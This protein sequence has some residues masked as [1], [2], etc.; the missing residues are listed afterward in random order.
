MASPRS[1]LYSTVKN[2]VEHVIASVN[3]D[4]VESCGNGDIKVKMDDL[5]DVISLI[6]NTSQ[7]ATIAAFIEIENFAN[8]HLQ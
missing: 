8:K 3:S 5:T 4:L 6:N 2:V 7:S 1:D